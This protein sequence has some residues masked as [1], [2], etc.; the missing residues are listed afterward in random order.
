MNN[1][2][3][4]YANGQCKKATFF[5]A[6]VNP[7]ILWL[8]FYEAIMGSRKHVYHF[9]YEI[10]K[11][12]QFH[13]HCIVQMSYKIRKRCQTSIFGPIKMSGGA[14]LSVGTVFLPHPSCTRLVPP[15]IHYPSP[16]T[17]LLSFYPTPSPSPCSLVI[18]PSQNSVSHWALQ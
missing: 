13:L 11:S 12:N 7:F 6:M 8:A 9:G 10:H 16:S 17:S 2:H 5:T 1:F 14:V 18:L 15:F 3:Q 4:M